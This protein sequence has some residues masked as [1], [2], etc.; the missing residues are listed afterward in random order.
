MNTSEVLE[1]MTQPPTSPSMGWI[2]LPIEYAKLVSALASSLD[3]YELAILI[4]FG[5]QIYLAG[6]QPQYNVPGDTLLA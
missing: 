6:A 5:R 2:Q 1:M 3:E 4:E